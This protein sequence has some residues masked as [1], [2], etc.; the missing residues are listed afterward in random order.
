MNFQ[1]VLIARLSAI[2]DVVFALPVLASL[3][4]ARPDL[5][6]GWLLDDRTSALLEGHEWIDD[7]IVYP[8]TK[9]KKPWSRP[10]RSLQVLSEHRRALRS[11]SYDVVLDLQGNLKG[12]MQLRWLRGAHRI[13]FG[14][15]FTREPSH[16]FMHTRVRPER[17]RLHRTEKFL[18]LLAPLDIPG[19]C[20]LPPPP[21]VP[22]EAHA[23]VE[24]KLAA[25]ARNEQGGPLIAMQPGVSRY[26]RDKQ[27]PAERYAELA[28]R[29][30]R[31]LDAHCVLIHAPFERDLAA[32]IHSRSAG[33]AC[34]DV[35]TANLK[36]LFALL[37]RSNL[38]I[39]SDSGPLHL[40]G[41]FGRPSLGLYGPTDPAV[42][43]PFGE[44]SK[45]LFHGEDPPPPRQRTRPDPTME[46]IT[47]DE[48]FEMSVDMLDS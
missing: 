31:E 16:W 27:W 22:D 36:E 1:S 47:V 14:R 25:S 7:L 9:L 26:G 38:F 30:V 13:G 40:A 17:E 12:A 43:G 33:A 37:A 44:K 8:R 39:G 6:I 48:V 32:S 34:D 11:R 42:Y 41:W 20:Q 29:F 18:S 46:R 45:T 15:G 3:R 21:H 4:R 23:E 5:R 2:G 28:R 24:R 10:R 19:Q 35:R